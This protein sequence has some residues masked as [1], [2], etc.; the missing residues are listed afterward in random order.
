ML[1]FPCNYLAHIALNR[2][3]DWVYV[4]E[5]CKQFDPRKIPDLIQFLQVPTINFFHLQV[6]DHLILL[7]HYLKQKVLKTSVQLY[8]ILE[9]E[10]R[11]VELKVL[12]GHVPNSFGQ[13][14]EKLEFF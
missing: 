11:S 3:F 12:L 4:L 2:I 7:R 14:K 1:S 5:I 6:S 8:T 13:N 10:A 9:V